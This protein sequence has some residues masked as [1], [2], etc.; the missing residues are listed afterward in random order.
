[1]AAGGRY[2]E[3]ADL[4]V[5]REKMRQAEQCG[6]FKT[7]KLS[8]ENQILYNELQNSP[9]GVFNVFYGKLQPELERLKDFLNFISDNEAVIFSCGKYGKFVHLLLEYYKKGQAK[10]YCDNNDALWND[11]VQG[12]TVLSPERAAAEYKSALYVIANLKNVNE[13]KSQLIKAMVPE[14]RIYV[15]QPDFSIELF[16]AHGCGGEDV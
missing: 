8:I 10:A 14:D 11:T 3:T 5:L 12:I 15:Y 1:M 16:F 6:I 2:Q 13:I 9:F 4:D 7:D